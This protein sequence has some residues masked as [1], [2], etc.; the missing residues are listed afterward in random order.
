MAPVGDADGGPIRKRPAMA[1]A[2][3]SSPAP[4][5]GLPTPVASPSPDA[6]AVTVHGVLLSVQELCHNSEVIHATQ[7]LHRFRSKVYHAAQRQAK[8]LGKDA[9]NEIASAASRE[10]TV[11]WHGTMNDGED[12]D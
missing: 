8:S 4:L 7:T 2:V 5:V 3:A 6:T 12:F 1:H 11:Y 10:G 9:A